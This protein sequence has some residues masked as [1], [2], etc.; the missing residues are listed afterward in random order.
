MICYVCLWTWIL[1]YSEFVLGGYESRKREL[2]N[3]LKSICRKR[4]ISEIIHML[5]RHKDHKNYYTIKEKYASHIIKMEAQFLVESSEFTYIN[6]MPG[7]LAES[8]NEPSM[9]EQSCMQLLHSEAGRGGFFAEYCG[10][11]WLKYPMF[12]PS[13]FIS[14]MS[15]CS[16]YFISVT[17]LSGN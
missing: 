11:D 4:G 9:P 3:Y 10:K 2:R 12:S 5:E 6:G 13:L 17:L 7:A 16:R 1:F 14:S 8:Y 15:V